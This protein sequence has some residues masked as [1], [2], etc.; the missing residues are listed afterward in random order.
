MSSSPNLL[1][2]F[3]RWVVG[4][5]AVAALIFAAGAIWADYAKVEAQLLTFRW[6]LAPPIIALTLGNYGLRFIKW[7]YLLGRLGVKM[8]LVDNIWNFVA[9]LAMVISPAKAGELLKPYVVR[10]RT[11]TPMSTTIPALAGERITDGIAM[12]LLA[13][14]SV[15]TYAAEYSRQLLVLPLLIGLGLAV[16]ASDRATAACFWVVDRL[17]LIRRISPKLKEMVAPLRVCFAPVPLLLT[18]L[19]SVIAWFAECV[20]YWLVFQG[21]GI[22]ANLDACTFIYAASTVLGGAAPGG[23]GMADGALVFFAQQILQV[24]EPQA[25]TS[26]LIVR[27]ATLWLG[28]FMGAIALLIAL[29]AGSGRNP[30][31]YHPDGLLRSST[32]RRPAVRGPGPPLRGPRRGRP[33]RRPP[34]DRD[35]PLPPG[36]P[37][38]SSSFSLAACSSGTGSP[39]CCSPWR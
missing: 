39:P 24:D 10:E 31:K 4:A 18:V 26:A 21:M 37:W 3:R 32:A 15:T 7:H 8:P 23:L 36:A 2:R 5:I 11:G 16:L 33:V 25:V 27:V 35:R 30:R 38:T 34:W 17:P 20:G 29:F 28:V 13:S 12:V 14:V 22:E 19:L 9:G 1:L 6:S